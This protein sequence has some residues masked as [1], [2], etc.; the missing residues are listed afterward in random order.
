VKE[1]KV[2]FDSLNKEFVNVIIE[3]KEA[4]SNSKQDKEFICCVCGEK[5]IAK[6]GTV[7]SRGHRGRGNGIR[8]YCLKCADIT[9]MWKNR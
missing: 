3:R 9:N 2:K 5:F 8:Y 1:L 7:I 6:I 4:F